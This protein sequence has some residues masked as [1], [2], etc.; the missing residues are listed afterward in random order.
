[1]GERV[2]AEDPGRERCLYSSLPGNQGPPRDLPPYYD[3]GIH[4][5]V[6]FPDLHQPATL[7]TL[8]PKQ[9]TQKLWRQM[10]I[11]NQEPNQKSDR[12]IKIHSRENRN[13]NRTTETEIKT[14]ATLHV[15]CGFVCVL[16]TCHSSGSR[17][18]LSHCQV[19]FASMQ[20]RGLHW[21]IFAQNSSKGGGRK[22]QRT[23]NLLLVNQQLGRPGVP[24]PIY[25]NNYLGSFPKLFY[26]GQTM[27]G[28]PHSW[29]N[30]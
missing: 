10:K 19:P 18:V 15:V 17:H 1:M 22:H 7:V 2:T 21:I 29:G 26:S 27:S 24:N 20:T 14:L 6:P 4:P 23:L 25:K 8:A 16:S 28:V 13:D 30:V 3:L 11:T 9:P 5:R 12:K